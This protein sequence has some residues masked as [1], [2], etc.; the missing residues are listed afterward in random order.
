MNLPRSPDRIGACFRKPDIA[1]QS[2]FDQ[3]RHGPHR[4]FDGHVRINTG[5]A[6]DI[7]TVDTEPLD[8]LLAVLRQV[9]RRAAAAISTRVWSPWAA[10]FGVDHDPLTPPL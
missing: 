7:K 3:P 8:A 2:A 5:H 1:S 4:L 9:F 6:K 10:G